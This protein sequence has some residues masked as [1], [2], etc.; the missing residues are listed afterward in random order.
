MI[1][2]PFSTPAYFNKEHLLYFKESVPVSGVGVVLVNEHVLEPDEPP[3][4]KVPPQALVLMADGKITPPI[5]KSFELWSM[6]TV[7]P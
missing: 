4:W 2:A 1:W 7:A 6:G 3:S 5:E